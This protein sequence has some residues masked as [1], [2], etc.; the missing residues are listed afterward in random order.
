M[1][2]VYGTFFENCKNAWRARFHGAWVL[3]FLYFP[4]CHICKPLRSSEREER[5]SFSWK[6][7]SL[8]VSIGRR[9]YRAA[10]STLNV[11]Q[12]SLATSSVWQ[13]AAK[14]APALAAT[15]HQRT[16]TGNISPQQHIAGQQLAWSSSFT[17]WLFFSF[18]LANY[19][20]GKLG[21]G[22]SHVAAAAA[23]ARHLL[24]G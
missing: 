20:D 9:P 17:L 23:V 10:I 19:F 14:V 24:C 11:E 18:P 8:S 21:D 3:F 15:S 2:P 5:R 16:A 7:L 4:G 22:N 1:L 6:R 13:S 12:H